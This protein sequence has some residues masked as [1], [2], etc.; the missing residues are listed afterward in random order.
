ME[1][2]C[3]DP[4]GWK[5]KKIS[6][7]PAATGSSVKLLGD[8]GWTPSATGSPRRCYSIPSYLYFSLLSRQPPYTSFNA[9]QDH[10][11][12]FSSYIT[13]N[14]I[15]HFYSLF[16]KSC[17]VCAGMPLLTWSSWCDEEDPR[18]WRNWSWCQGRRGLG[19]HEI[20]GRGLWSGSVGVEAPEEQVFKPR[21]IGC[22]GADWVKQG[23][24]SR[25]GECPRE[26]Q[27]VQ[28]S[29]GEEEWGIPHTKWKDRSPG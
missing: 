14:I 7:S 29:R 18:G 6:H 5:R 2:W 4:P 10:L 22:I 20:I 9:S 17:D 8:S 24:D 19:I 21:P 25:R 3:T 1:W 23:W 27:H 13:L 26:G 11:G 28:R 16:V 15:I 12:F